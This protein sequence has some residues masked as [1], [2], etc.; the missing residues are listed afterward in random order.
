MKLITP[1]FT[2]KV[3]VTSRPS[4]YGVL[5]NIVERQWK[6]DKRVY[7]NCGPFAIDTRDPDFKLVNA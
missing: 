3:T 1:K 5:L 7:K 2:A 6:G 4:E